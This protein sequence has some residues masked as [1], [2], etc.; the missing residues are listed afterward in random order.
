M[1]KRVA[2][3]WQ[4]VVGVALVLLVIAL[5]PPTLNLYE[6]T[7]EENLAA[8]LRGVVHWVNTA[9]RPQP[10][11]A[12]DAAIQ[13]TAVPPF[14]VNTFLQQEVEPAKREQSLFLL[15]TPV[16]ASSAR[17]LPGKTLRFTAKAILKTGA[18]WTPSVWSMPGPSMTDS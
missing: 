14:G 6:L 3:L 8:Q 10:S 18:T 12:P 15:T 2:M 17:N 16:F 5:V 9:V 13:Q 4:M 11:L 7:G 1:S